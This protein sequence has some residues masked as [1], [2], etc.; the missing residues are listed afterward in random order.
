MIDRFWDNSPDLRAEADHLRS[1]AAAEGTRDSKN[2]DRLDP[3]VCE[4]LARHPISAIPPRP[5]AYGKF[6]LFGVPLRSVP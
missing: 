3:L 4:P 6:L 1:V 2:N 5:W